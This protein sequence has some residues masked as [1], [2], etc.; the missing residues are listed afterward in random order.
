MLDPTRTFLKRV[1]AGFI[2]SCGWV[3]ILLLGVL[4]RMSGH[5]F[6]F[7]IF[8]LLPLFFVAWYTDAKFGAITAFLATLTWAASNWGLDENPPPL[9]FQAWNVLIEFGFYLIFV[10]LLSGLKERTRLLE[11][12]A[13]SD[14][15]TGATNRR[16]FYD[17]LRLEV[18]RSKRYA[19]NISIAYI[20][21]DNFKTI[22]DS[23]GHGAGDEALVAVTS[24][25]RQ[26]LRNL[27]SVA[28]FGGDE[29]TILLPET[30]AEDARKAIRK[31]GQIL[32]KNIIV[33]GSAVTFSIG[34]VT[35]K[36][37][38][39][40]KEQMIEAVDA[41]MYAAKKSGKDQIRFEVWPKSN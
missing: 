10:L 23:Y 38:P 39:E 30:N 32:R 7:G 16:Y 12:M 9:V 1:P 33:R 13:T 37:F 15:L 31:I 6:E 4:D 14:P 21:I 36:E 22:N 20:D 28:R 25:L 24:V 19:A 18:A 41:V 8:Y 29:F 40:T 11:E 5:E 27:D 26:N 17:L 2:I 34:V 3:T 35:F